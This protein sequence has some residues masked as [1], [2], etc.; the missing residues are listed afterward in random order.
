MSAL[1]FDFVSDGQS[2][3]L[4]QV[5]TQLQKMK[6]MYLAR[7]RPRIVTTYRSDANQAADLSIGPTAIDYMG[8]GDGR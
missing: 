6:D 5:F 7:M 1:Q 4:S 3:R 8:S 2:F